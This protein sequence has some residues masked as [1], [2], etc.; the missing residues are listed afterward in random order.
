MTAPSCIPSVPYS[1]STLPVPILNPSC[2]HPEPFLYPFCTLPVPFLYPSCTPDRPYVGLR[3]VIFYLYIY[4]LIK[5]FS[6][7]I[8]FFKKLTVRVKMDMLEMAK[9]A[10]VTIFNKF[11]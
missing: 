5:I 6:R 2:T 7:R 11:V 9:T 1:S 4:L 8:K 10:L 3:S